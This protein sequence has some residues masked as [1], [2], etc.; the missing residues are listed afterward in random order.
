MQHT[1]SY[2]SKITLIVLAIIGIVTGIYGIG[3]IYASGLLGIRCDIFKTIIFTLQSIRSNPRMND[4]EKTEEE[5]EEEEEEG[6]F[7]IS[8]LRF[9]SIFIYIDLGFQFFSGT[10][11]VSL[12]HMRG[13]LAISLSI[14]E[15]VNVAAMTIFLTELIHKVK[16]E[17]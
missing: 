4:E 9:L 8:L 14:L 17:L 3:Q 7:D 15:A 11:Q 13:W 12:G 1:T 10:T 6:H 16:L 2:L 5:E